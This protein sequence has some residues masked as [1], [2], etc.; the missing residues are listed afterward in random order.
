[1][2]HSKAAASEDFAALFDATLAVNGPAMIEVDMVSIG[3]FATVFAGPPA[4]AAG[5]AR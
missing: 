5:G 4:G 3:P 2:P 1:M